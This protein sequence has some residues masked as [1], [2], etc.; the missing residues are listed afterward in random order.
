MTDAKQMPPSV[1]PP[2]AFV[3]HMRVAHTGTEFFFDFAQA[4]QQADTSGAFVAAQLVARLVMTP[5]HAKAMLGALKE[6]LAKYEL[7]Y[8]E[9]P[10]GTSRSS[11]Q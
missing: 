2:A 7:A 10:N 6:N 4:S 11:I 8:G 3:N 5:Q 9:I 1:L